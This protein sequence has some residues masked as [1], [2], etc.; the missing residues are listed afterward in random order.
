[1]RLNPVQ[2]CLTSSVW[3][4][5]VF[6]H[7][8]STISSR[9]ALYYD[10]PNNDSFRYCTVQEKRPVH[11]GA[12]RF[13]LWGVAQGTGDSLDWCLSRTNRTSHNGLTRW[14]RCP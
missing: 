3:E 8:V 1:V 9:I 10:K 6:E 5:A 4:C 2:R 7:V 14:G 11:E 13:C 12:L